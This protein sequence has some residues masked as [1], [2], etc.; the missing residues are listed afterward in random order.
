M[1]ND[2]RAKKRSWGFL[3]PH[4]LREK[5]SRIDLLQDSQILLHIKIMPG[6]DYI[7]V[8]SRI[9]GKWDKEI[10]LKLEDIA[11]KSDVEI[12]ILEEE[13][14]LSIV[15]PG[16]SKIFYNRHISQIYES[17]IQSTPGIKRIKLS[18]EVNLSAVTAKIDHAD[19][20]RVTGD[21]IYPD[22]EFVNSENLRGA[23]L[24][25]TVDGRL[26]GS[27][28]LPKASEARLSPTA[29]FTID[30]D[31]G[32]F[33][34]DGMI[35]DIHLLANDR[36]RLLASS[37]LTSVF[38]GGLECC[39]EAYVAGFL[40]NAR[41]PDRAVLVDIF[42][43]DVFHATIPTSIERNDLPF[44]DNGKNVAGFQFRFPKAI[45]LP[46]SRDVAI[47]ARIHNTDV[48]LENSPWWISRAVTFDKKK[49]LGSKIETIQA[50]G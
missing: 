13:D 5:T 24:L 29:Q 50:L 15:P 6:F 46:L 19:I 31:V 22:I 25:L 4:A 49:G 3:I 12:H 30:L 11:E 40:L 43:D 10:R 17:I 44:L 34:S 35:A 20:M 2:S 23:Q 1:K 26:S 42:V 47:S 28:P 36:R 16:N 18:D 41:F 14:Y 9:D 32:A 21:L 7:V 27:I 48:E 45:S 37:H 8:N 33:V 38:S 39:T